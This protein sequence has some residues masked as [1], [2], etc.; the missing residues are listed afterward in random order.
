MYTIKK[1]AITGMLFIIMMFAY[2]GTSYAKPVT[3]KV[4]LYGKGGVSGDSGGGKLCPD[5]DSKV[6]AVIEVTLET[7]SMPGGSFTIDP[8]VTIQM[9]GQERIRATLIDADIK[10]IDFENSTGNFENVIVK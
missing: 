8:H 6:C 3:I 7:S 9:P 5:Q 10:G 4:T 2:V 1:I